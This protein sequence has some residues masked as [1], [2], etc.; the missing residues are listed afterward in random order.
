MD[1][2]LGLYVIF[3]G[4]E[5]TGKTSTINAVAEHFKDKINP[6]LTHH[7]GS[8]PLGAH[9]RQLVKYPH[10]ISKDIYIDP[11]TR[12]CL[13]MADT[14]SFV[15]SVLKPSLKEGR[16][17]FADRSTYISGLVY[18]TADNVNPREIYKLLQ[19]IEPPLADRLYILHCPWNITRQR[20]TASRI[21]NTDHYDNQSDEFFEKV[22]RK[23]A[24][25]LTGTPELLMM[26]SRVAR[27]DNIIYINANRPQQQVV[28]DIIADLQ[29]HIDN[30][31]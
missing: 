21:N 27:L 3:E 30:L 13:Y 5:G 18:G 2:K 1:S 9:L 31:S 12:Q 6:Q 28:D 19:L 26:V 16:T 23:Y 7:P 15:E 10:E 22:D 20:I 8:T 14:I 25:L 24:E 4:N 11:L 17:V 29:S